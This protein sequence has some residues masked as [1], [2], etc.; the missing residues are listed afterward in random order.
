[1]RYRRHNCGGLHM[2]VSNELRVS[3]RGLA[4][5][6]Y[7]ARLD[8]PWLDTPFPLE[9]LK[10]ETDEEVEKL[11]RICS[12]VFVDTARGTS[13]DLRYVEHDDAEASP[14]RQ[15]DEYVALRKVDWKVD[16]EFE[17]ERG[18]AKEVHERLERDIDEVM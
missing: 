15:S 16:T 11:R 10:L 1:M 17:A 7:V 13:P 14:R 18:M 6:M 4:K 12:Y 8:R 3:V 2:L 9:G 5:G